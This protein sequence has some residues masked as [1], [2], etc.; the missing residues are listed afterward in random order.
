MKTVWYTC[1]IHNI[2][3]IVGSRTA[4]H[5]KIHSFCAAEHM[6]TCSQLI[7]PQFQ[8]HSSFTYFE[9]PEWDPPERFSSPCLLAQRLALSVESPRGTQANEGASL[10][11]SN[12]LY[13]PSCFCGILQQ[14]VCRTRSKPPLQHMH[15]H[16]WPGHSEGGF[17]VNSVTT[18]I[19]NFL[20]SSPN[21]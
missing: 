13:F 5:N 8:I 17:S 11:I 14:M 12:I 4:L 21:L 15:T 19:G 9:T 2:T 6:R 1:C 7:A 18:S 3:H 20:L 10:P 16:R